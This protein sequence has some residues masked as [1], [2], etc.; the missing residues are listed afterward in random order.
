MQGVA[1]RQ[2][3]FGPGV[4]V[5]LPSVAADDA[6]AERQAADFLPAPD[7]DFL[8]NAAQSQPQPLPEEGRA[9]EAGQ[10]VKTQRR[11][12][13][14]GARR[15]SRRWRRRGMPRTPSGWRCSSA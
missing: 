10:L 14:G 12:G 13:S 15:V 9:A 1:D 4:D 8:K 7:G 11:P 5:Q 2:A 3:S 6:G